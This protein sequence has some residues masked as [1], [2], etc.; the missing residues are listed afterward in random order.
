M[1]K[2]F[3]LIS[4]YRCCTY[5][6]TDLQILRGGIRAECCFLPR[7]G[8]GWAPRILDTHGGGELSDVTFLSFLVFT[9][10]YQRLENMST[11]ESYLTGFGFFFFDPRDA[12]WYLILKISEILNKCQID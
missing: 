9:L 1:A 5:R 12:A 6:N 11:L 4:S 3:F 2:K 10:Y 8:G 7:I